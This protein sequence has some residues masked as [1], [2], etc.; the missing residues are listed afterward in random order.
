M[1]LCQNFILRILIIFLSVSL[2]AQKISVHGKIVNEQ[3]EPVKYI[4]ISLLQ[5]GNT[6]I[7]QALPMIQEAFHFRLIKEIIYYQ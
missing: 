1:E 5:N 6:K 2:P 7:E 4:N 3:N